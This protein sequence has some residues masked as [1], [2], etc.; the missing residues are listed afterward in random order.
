MTM[1]HDT[2]PDTIGSKLIPRYNLGIVKNISGQIDRPRPEKTRSLKMKKKL[3]F[4]KG[5]KK[6]NK[7][8]T[9]KQSRDF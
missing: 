7:N 3:N 4:K 2:H 9:K 8:K 6:T 5:A 1:Q